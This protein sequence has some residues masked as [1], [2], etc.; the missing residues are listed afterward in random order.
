MSEDAA[1]DAIYV[2]F[3]FNLID[4]VSDALGFELK[5]EQGYRHDA[6]VLLKMGYKLP[7]PLRLLARNPAW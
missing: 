1:R 3:A 5:D 6:H 4:R 7:G 2:C